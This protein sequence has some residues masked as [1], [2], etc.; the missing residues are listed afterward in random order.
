LNKKDDQNVGLKLVSL[1]KQRRDL[2]HQLKRLRDRQMQLAD[3]AS[4]ELLLKILAGR[5]KLI[6]KLRELE[7]KLSLIKSNWSKISP[8]L[9]AEYK[10]QARRMLEQAG[11]ITE[12][13]STNGLTD[14][15][16][17]L[18]ECK[19]ETYDELLVE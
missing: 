4:P 5:R 18:P 15:P 3:T 14:K 17:D 10:Q 1:L 6:E 11:K 19:F 8:Q 9:G 16:G 2:Y 13:I 7:A 12:E